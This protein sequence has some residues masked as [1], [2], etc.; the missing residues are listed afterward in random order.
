MTL[1]VLYWVLMLLWLLFSLWIDYV[2]NQPYPVRRGAW[3]FMIF[4]LLLIL[5]WAVFGSPV[6]H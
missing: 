1:A 4:V 5:G 2:P 3:S 6:K